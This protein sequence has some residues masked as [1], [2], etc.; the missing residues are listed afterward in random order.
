MS[1]DKNENI[2]IPYLPFVSYN[3]VQADNLWLNHTQ[4]ILMSYF[5]Y[6]LPNYWQPKKFNNKNFYWMSYS[7][8]FADLPTLSMSDNTLRNHIN[9]LIWMGMLERE[10]WRKDWEM[11][12]AFYR[13]TP[14]FLG[15]LKKAPLNFGILYSNLEELLKQGAIKVDEKDRIKTLL[16]SYSGKKKKNDTT[17]NLEWLGWSSITDYLRKEF[18]LCEKGEGIDLNVWCEVNV[19]WIVENMLDPIRTKWKLNW[20]ID[21]WPNWD[22]QMTEDVKNKVLSKL[23]TMFQWLKDNN[24]EV[25]SM[26]GNINTFF[27]KS[28]I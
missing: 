20:W 17:F 6:L 14:L 18:E 23:H 1:T 8:A 19:K 5:A 11:S 26:K 2:Q 28:W 9:K 25:K 7:K 27:W 15:G 22:Y 12:K 24:R 4:A 13:A 10:V 16:S 3:Q 21:A